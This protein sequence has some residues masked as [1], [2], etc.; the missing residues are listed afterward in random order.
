MLFFAFYRFFVDEIF[1]L[2]LQEMNEQQKCIIPLDIIQRLLLSN[3]LNR[4]SDGSTQQ[5]EV[6]QPSQDV[7]QHLAASKFD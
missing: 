6:W 4:P 2:I 3:E 1:M 7:L 5:R